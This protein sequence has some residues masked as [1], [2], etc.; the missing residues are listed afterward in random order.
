MYC[1]YHLHSAF[2]DDSDYPMEDVIKDAIT[3]GLDEICFT[4]H[5]DYGVKDEYD[6]PI[7]TSFL[8]GQWIHNV[9]YPAYFKALEDLSIKYQSK[10]KI[11][12]GLEFGMQKHTI[13]D[14]AKLYH[15]YEMDFIL[16]SIHQIGDVE[17][18]LNEFQKGKSQ[19]EY[20]EAYYKELYYLVQN[21]KDYSVLGHMDLMR[22]YDMN[23]EY[24]FKKVE[25][26]IAAI[27]KQVI[28]DER[29]IE[30][31]TSSSR[32]GLKDTM[33]S[34]D[35]LKLYL[36]LGGKIITIGSDSHHPNH[37]GQGIKEAHSYLYSLGYRQF[38]TFKRMVPTFHDLQP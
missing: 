9:D 30:L 19:K 14:F 20:N 4:D 33:P 6:A 18:W 16:L 8:D 11:K 12:K 17:F 1:D 23:G 21:Y 3:N 37:L 26:I 22:R 5:V 32:Y 31:N 38:C 28:K 15:K 27:L 13:K 29:G 2:S 25:A 10:I 35:I 7:H 24:P 36:D 34:K